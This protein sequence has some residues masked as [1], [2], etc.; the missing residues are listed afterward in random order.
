MYRYRGVRKK[1]LIDRKYLWTDSI[2]EAEFIKELVDNGFSGKWRR[3]RFGLGAG[4]ARYTPDVE[5]SILHDGMNRHALVEFKS[6]SAAEFTPKRRRAMLAV[7]KFYID[8]I[9]LLYVERTKTWFQVEPHGKLHKFDPPTPGGLPIDQLS[10]PKIA[11]P[12]MNGYGRAYF[13]R[14]GNF[15]LKKTADGMEFFV[16]AFFASPKYKKRNM[17]K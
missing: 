2:M 15:V 1:H 9:C 3:S 11:I 8:S 7:S 17:H 16:K 5:L 14:P 4:F 13:V 10:R 12:I 6:T